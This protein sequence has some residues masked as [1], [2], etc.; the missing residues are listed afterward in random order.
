MCHLLLKHGVPV[1]IT[2]ILFSFC[3]DCNT[4]YMVQESSHTQATVTISST[5]EKQRWRPGQQYTSSCY[6][7]SLFPKIVPLL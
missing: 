3:S 6:R 5:T 1:G 2:T 7:P 4:T